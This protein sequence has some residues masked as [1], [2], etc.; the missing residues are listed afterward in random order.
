MNDL[1]CLAQSVPDATAAPHHDKRLEEDH[2]K[3]ATV[4]PDACIETT[5]HDKRPQ[6]SSIAP[7]T[8][9][10]QESTAQAFPMAEIY[11][12]EDCIVPTPAATE[13]LEDVT[14]IKMNVRVQCPERRVVH[15][16][17]ST[18]LDPLPHKKP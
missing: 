1:L 5:V 14:N 9:P 18:T 8:I 3:H 7:T 10:F 6:D 15:N 12:A 2:H 11:Y 16:V 13:P 17:D 4:T